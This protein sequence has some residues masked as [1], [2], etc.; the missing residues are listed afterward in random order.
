MDVSGNQ[1]TVNSYST[2][3]APRRFPT[4]VMTSQRYGQTTRDLTPYSRMRHEELTG[5]QLVKKFPAFYETR[6]FITAFTN[7]RPAPLAY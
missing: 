4:I 5:S 1:S 2:S 7:A 6:R 3:A